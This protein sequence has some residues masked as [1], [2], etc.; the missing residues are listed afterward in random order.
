[1]S[2]QDSNFVATAFAERLQA[3]IGTTPQAV[4]AKRAQLSTSVLGKYLQG[5]EPGLVKASRL[6]RVL[7]VNLQWLADG[8]GAPNVASAGFVGVPI[9]DVRLAAG[10]ASFADGAKVI[11]EMPFDLELLRQ[12]GRSSA[13]G[14]GVLG[15]DGDSMEPTIADGA[16]VV[17]DFKDTRAREDVFAFRLGDELRVKRLRRIVDGLEILSDNPRYA[18]ELLTGPKLEDFAVIGRAL[19]AGA[20]L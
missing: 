20:I 15:A 3:A 10:A 12:L 11:G 9:Y 6:A 18:P 5:S 2:E 16:R 4:V 1:M 19:W 7:G 8:E 13:D 14:L 17:I